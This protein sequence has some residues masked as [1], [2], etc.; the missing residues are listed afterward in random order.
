MSR[1]TVEEVKGSSHN[2]TES[3]KYFQSMMINSNSSS[4]NPVMRSS[5]DIISSVD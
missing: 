4:S 3:E 2:D 5:R 1:N